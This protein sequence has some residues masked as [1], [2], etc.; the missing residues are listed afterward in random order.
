MV[1]GGRHREG[2]PHMLTVANSLAFMI[3]IILCIVGVIRRPR[4]KLAIAG[5][6]IPIFFI[7]FALFIVKC[8]I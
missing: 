1:I 3:G 2:I 6:A 5:L 7:V 4:S 8:H